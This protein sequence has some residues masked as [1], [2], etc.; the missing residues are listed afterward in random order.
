M[1][2]PKRSIVETVLLSVVFGAAA[3]VV[4]MLYV[5][6]YLL[7]QPEVA[8]GGFPVMRGAGD[9]L[10]G[11]EDAVVVGGEEAARAAVRFFPW[12]ADAAQAGLDGPS[13][14][15]RHRLPDDALASG[16]VLTSDGWLLSYGEAASKVARKAAGSR[17]SALVAGREFD[18][19]EA[20]ADSYTGVVFLKID[21]SNLPVAAISWRGEPL[22]GELLYAFDAAG[23]LRRLDVLGMGKAPI[24]EAGDLL[25]SSERMQKV[26]RL[27]SEPDLEAGALLMDR[28]GQLVAIYAGDGG[29]G[30]TAIPISAFSGQI[31]SV[32]RTKS[33]PRPYLGVRFVDLSMV[34]DLP[35]GSPRRGALVSASADGKT[36]AVVRRSPAEEAGLRPGDVITAVDGE[37]VSAGRSLSDLIAEFDAGSAVTLTVERRGTV[38]PVEVTLGTAP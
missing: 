22:P 4:G 1:S 16:V 32:L 19:L 26:L 10:A 5:A 28:S 35:E 24:G 38:R 29:L 7:P 27:T 33:S 11:R 37:E 25:R 13:L 21:G 34:S 2:Q 14:I 23:G 20:V 36:P 17:F 31:G 15:R 12:R 6:L 30:A 8:G 18:V 3:G 9:S